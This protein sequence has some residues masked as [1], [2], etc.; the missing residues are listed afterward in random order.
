MAMLTDQVNA[1]VERMAG[2]RFCLHCQQQRP[3]DGFRLVAGVKRERCASCAD[4][5]E[6]TAAGKTTKRPA[7]RVGG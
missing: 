6:A 2:T 3:V 7:R 4:K 5:T 1:A